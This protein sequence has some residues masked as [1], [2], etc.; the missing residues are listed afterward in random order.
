MITFS[1]G[2][3]MTF[4][5]AAQ[6]MEEEG[7]LGTVVLYDLHSHLRCVLGVLGNITEESRS[8]HI[9][10]KINIVS[11]IWLANDTF[12]G[13]PEERAVYMAQW[14]RNLSVAEAEV[15]AAFIQE[16][17]AATE[18][19]FRQLDAGN[20]VTLDEIRDMLDE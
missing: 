1:D 3:T 20:Y 9:P 12:K 4:E 2:T 5:E 7:R 11:D 18:E 14:F 13:T 16:S 15:E 19:G 8:S 10:Y 6:L 17:V